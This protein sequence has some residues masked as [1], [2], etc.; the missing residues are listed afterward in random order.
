LDRPIFNKKC[1]GVL[2]M[3][4]IILM[5]D[6]YKYSQWVQYPPKTEYVYSYIESRGGMYD[7]TVFFG[8]QAF[9]KEYLR[10]PVTMEMIDEAEEVVVCAN[11]PFNRE[12]W[13]H[14]VNEHDGYLPVVIRG[15]PEGSIIETKN[16]LVDIINT[17]PKCFWLTSFLE[18][19]LLR[20]IWYPTTVATNSYT[21]KQIIL[22][23]LHRS[24]DPSTINF[25]LQDF[26]ARGVSSHE[27]AK[28]G[29]AAHLI[30][31]MGSDTIEC[32][33]FIRQYYNTSDIVGSSIPAMEHSTVTSWGRDGE[34]DSFSNMLD[35]FAKPGEML[36]CVSDSYDIYAACALW[37]TELKQK[38]ID[39]GATIIIRPDS[40]DPADVVTKCAR[41]LDKH[42]GSVRN[43]K[44]YKVINYVRIIQGDGIDHQSIRSILFSL[45]NA[46][47]S[48]DNVGFGQGGAL[49]Q[50][51]NRDTL[52]F[53]M[54]CS[55]A[56]VDGKWIDVF[57]D[58]IT[59]QGKLSKKGILRLIKEDGEFKTI[60][61]SESK[62]ERNYLLERFG[63]GI[64]SN[65]T[66]FEEVRVRAGEPFL[67]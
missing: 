54:K 16:V 4:N 34:F 2:Q 63:N 33:Q 61:E 36:A 62:G 13:E 23:A 67:N 51:V 37:G 57:K 48:S 28:I 9:L 27:S 41:I 6:A 15:A 12:G 8:L 42:F 46:G 10:L 5:S 7:K 35:H 53:A 24:G 52:K 60:R 29:G 40:G 21:S 3:T 59:D 25:K 44:G 64:L 65:E 50:Q 14:I 18:T 11:M 45:A 55:A 26:G 58:P 19:A 1:K 31:F 39:S 47:Y 38:V 32:L 66:T 20:A 30:N 22:E 49:L 17:D 43:E 56:Y